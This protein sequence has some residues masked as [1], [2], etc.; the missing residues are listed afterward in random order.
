VRCE[1][2]T[3]FGGLVAHEQRLSQE[4]AGAI[5]GLI[6]ARDH[7]IDTESVGYA[8]TRP[9]IVGGSQA[10]RAANRRV[11][12]EVTAS[13]PAPRRPGSLAVIVGDSSVTLTFLVSAH[14]RGAPVSS[15]E[16]SLDGGAHWRKLATHGSG[17]VSATIVG[18]T[19]GRAY[20]IL[21]R[22]RD[23]AGSS[24]ASSAISF[25]PVASSAPTSTG[26]GAVEGLSVSSGS[27]GGGTS[28]SGESVATVPG[29]PTLSSVTPEAGA[30][31]LHFNAPASNGGSAVTGYEYS[32]DGGTSWQSATTS[33]SGPYTAHVSGLT[34]GT[35]YQFAVRAVNAVG[36]GA[37]SN[38]LPATPATVPGAPTLSSVTPGEG[39][40][41]LHFSAPA[42]NGGSV[43]TGYQYS[44]DGGSTWQTATVSGDYPKT[45][46]VTGLTNGT[47]YRFAVRTVNSVGDSASSNV[48]S[49]TPLGVPAAPTLSSV[50]PESGAVTLHFAAPAS[51]GGSEVT[52]YE[53][54]SDG[55]TSWQSATTSGSGPYSAKVTGLTNGTEYQ[56]A[57]RALNTVGDSARSNVLAATPSTATV[58]SKPEILSASVSSNGLNWVVSLSFTTPASNGAPITGYVLS[59]LGPG[60]YQPLSYTSG[61]PNTASFELGESCYTEVDLYLFLEAVNTVGAS[62]PSRGYNLYEEEEAC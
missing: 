52:G 30:V 58:P 61:S 51:D 48:L 9:V 59:T 49:G 6:D 44:S 19:N 33:G 12:V 20:T 14:H 40:V 7:S 34:N 25:T 55:G 37:S 43:I 47:E 50:T 35:E 46:Q 62:A 8:G 4:R 57:V 42:S 23:V 53:Y 3:D 31:T 36:D 5:C 17:R 24:E 60:N 13:L 22:A 1:G 2:Y 54:S 10:D 29:A 45:A 18:L 11:I 27:S 32:S 26:S 28:G 15:Y 38:V 56:F 21:V 16:Y 41:T 39:A